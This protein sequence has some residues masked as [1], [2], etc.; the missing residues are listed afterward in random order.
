MDPYTGIA[1]ENKFV[2]RVYWDCQ[3]N[4]CVNG[5]NICIDIYIHTQQDAK[6]EN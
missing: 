3:H 5:S 4:C 6:H 2:Q 1:N